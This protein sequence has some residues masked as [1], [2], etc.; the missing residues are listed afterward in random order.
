MPMT[1]IPII[2]LHTTDEDNAVALIPQNK[3]SRRGT[4]VMR[5]DFSGG[6]LDLSKWEYEIS[7]FGGYVC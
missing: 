5:D 4:V 2:R 3:P 6:S 1:Y 7:M